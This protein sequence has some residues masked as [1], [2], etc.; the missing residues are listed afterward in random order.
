M[1][2]LDEMNLSYKSIMTT[3]TA[4]FLI[5]LG[6]HASITTEARALLSDKTRSKIKSIEAIV[7]NS[8]AQKIIVNFIVLLN[9]P[10][11]PT[12]LFT[13]EEKALEWLKTELPQIPI[14]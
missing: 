14:D 12:K 3:T 4:P 11:Q 9:K 8:L 13:S 5:V 10:L 6:R 2:D 7:V 1:E